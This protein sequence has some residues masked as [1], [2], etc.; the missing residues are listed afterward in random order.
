MGRAFSPTF[1]VEDDE[2][3]CARRLS[4]WQQFG[5]F[6][7]APLAL[8]AFD[9]RARIR[10]MSWQRLISSLSAVVVSG[11]LA[12]ACSD[13][14]ASGDTT[15]TG[16]TSNTTSS[17]SAN[18]NSTS[19]SSSSVGS[20]SASTSSA[21]VSGAT[22]GNA[23]SAG[24]GGPTS[25]G[26]TIGGTGGGTSGSTTTGAPQGN[27]AGGANSV[28]SASGTTDG[29][30]AQSNGCGAATWPSSGSDYSLNIDG[31]DRSYILRI[32]DD[33]DPNHPYRLIVAFHWLGGTADNVAGGGGV[34]KGPFYGLW[35]LAEGSTIFV[36]PQGIDNAWPDDGRTNSAEGRD[37]KFART[38]IEE[39][40]NTLCIDNTRIFAEGFSMGGSMS[41]ALA[42]AVGST[43]RGVAA[44]SG[45]PMSGCVQ[46]DTPV[47]Y[48]MT[49][50]TMDTVCTYPQFGVPQVN[51]FAEVNGCMPREMPTP[52]GQAPSCVDF[53]GCSE[54]YPTRA[55]IFVGDHTPS[56]PSTQNTWVPE[57]TWNFISQ[58]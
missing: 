41:Y 53:E 12:V 9:P 13:D 19:A 25:G 55:C 30:S 24:T 34:L 3:V 37:V 42:C 16:P 10:I 54:G 40:Q 15:A 23:S 56:P 51:D 1:R 29:G 50:G 52:S 57:E 28:S 38:L 22:T 49:H 44:H 18:A 27:A 35:E 32:P 33:Y 58:F 20:Q 46:H 45:G 39:L 7:N 2:I 26:M 8:R 47:A 17:S 4:T 48:F 5:S 43:L 21:S 31:T 6:S 11:S 14:A 36:A